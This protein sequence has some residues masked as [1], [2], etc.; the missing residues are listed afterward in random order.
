MNRVTLLMYHIIDHP[1]SDKEARYCCAP[2]LF[3]KHMRHLAESG[4]M[5][6][7]EDLWSALNG[8]RDLMPDAVAVTF[9]DGFAA[10]F[11]HALP[12]L[13]RYRIPATMFVVSGRVGGYNDWMTPRGFPQRALMTEK[14]IF[15]MRDAGVTMGSH[16]RTHPRLS[17]LDPDLLAAEITGSRT[18]LEMLLGQEVKDFAY[19]FGLYDGAAREAVRAAGY[20]TACSTRAGFNSADISRYELRRIEVYGWDALWRFRQKLKYGR[21]ESG[22]AFPITYY[23]GRARTHLGL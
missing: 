15:A 18:D 17:G 23:L 1:L 8:D 21:N 12:A 2:E 13:L 20:R 16:T 10:T 19:P 11:D 7:L 22:F 3:E 5:I 4:R 6:G 9:D 14:Q